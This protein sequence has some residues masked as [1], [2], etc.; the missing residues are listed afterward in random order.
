MSEPELS[1]V[2]IGDL[3]L[4]PDERAELGD[5]IRT[6]QISEGPK[7]CAFEELWA[8]Y[9]GTDYAVAL[10][11]GTSALVA[12]LLALQAAHDRP[13]HR[14]MGVVTSPLTYIST[15]NA[16]ML[17]GC[18]PAFVDV[19][20]DTFCI[21]PDAVRAHLESVDDPSFYGLVLP[22][23]LMGYPCDMA[24]MHTVAQAYG[25][26]I[27]ED[28]AQAHGT[29]IG[30]K[31]T[32]SLSRLSDFSFYI[33][34]NVQAGEMGMITTDDD[35][36]ARLVRKIKANGRV[37]DC[38]RCTRTADGCPQHPGERDPRFTHDIIGYNFKASE[39]HAAIGLAQARK[40]EETIRIRKANFDYLSEG[41]ENASGTLRLPPPVEGVSHFAYPMVVEDASVSRDT[42]CRALGRYGIETRPLF[43]CIPTQQPAFGKFRV[44]YEGHLPNAEHLGANGFYVGCHQYLSRGDLDRII[45]SVPM[46]LRDIGVG[47]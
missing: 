35:E 18:E 7:V 47:V 40:V 2:P 9:V 4:G 32:G 23:H 14:G 41:L 38:P 30:G 27:F 45:A 34:H 29:L 11:S 22:V 20:P 3:V 44:W 6:S 36:L 31:R 13:L 39:F 12:G 10:N 28:S 5:V 43:G 24:G 19:D 42:L 17:T 16:V 25:L 21:T 8:E 33:A 1:P 26:D 46:A 15:S 37:C